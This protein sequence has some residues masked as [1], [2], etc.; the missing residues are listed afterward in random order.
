MLQTL[1]DTAYL[2]YL[3]LENNC[4]LGRDRTNFG[5]W[6]LEYLSNVL[7]IPSGYMPEVV[8]FSETLEPIYHELPQIPEDS[9]R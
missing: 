4:L 7:P 5:R 3:T 6:I 1:A 9:K 8:G 2:T